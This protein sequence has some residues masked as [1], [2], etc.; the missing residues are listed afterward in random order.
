VLN[1]ALVLHNRAHAKHRIGPEA[2]I[3]RVARKEVVA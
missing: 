3:S 1:R 2:E